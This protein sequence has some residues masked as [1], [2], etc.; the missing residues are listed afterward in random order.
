MHVGL[1]H[2]WKLY[3][4]TLADVILILHLGLGQ[5]RTARDAPVNRLLAAIDKS[6]LNQ[7]GEQTQFLRLV[8][9]VQREVWVVP[10]AQ[11]TK[12]LELLALRVDE[13]Q[14]VLLARLADGGRRGVGVAVLAHLLR[15]L[16]FDRQSVA[17]PAR[18]IRHMFA[19]QRL[20][21]ENEVLENL[22]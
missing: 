10:L 12:P 3:I 1:A 13:A 16:E 9:G 20:V 8:S 6:L 19:A 17:V 21:L 11:H 7:V 15:D 18:H 22:V 5:R 4:H 2:N 14:R